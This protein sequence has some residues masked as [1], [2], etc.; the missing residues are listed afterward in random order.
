MN[1]FYNPLQTRTARKAHRCTWCGEPID[2]GSTYVHQT[3]VYDNRWF[4]NKMHPECF[5]DMCDGDGEWLPYSN[6][7]PR[8][9]M[10]GDKL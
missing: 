7:R 4:S 8:A 3:G 9:A 1:D 5:E 10:S 2:T 6:E